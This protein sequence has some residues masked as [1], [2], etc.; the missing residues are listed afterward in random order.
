MQATTI[1]AG[2]LLLGWVFLLASRKDV[3]LVVDGR[4]VAVQ[5]TSGNVAELLASTG[6][7][8]DVRVEPPPATALADGMTVIVSPPPGVPAD[9]LATMVDPHGVG[10]WVVERSDPSSFGKATSGSGEVMASAD[11]V[12]SSSSVSVRAVVSGK[13][14]HVVT[15]ASSVGALLSAMGID[16]DA[17]DRVAPPPTTPLHDRSTVRYDEVAVVERTRTVRVPFPTMTTYTASLLP[18]QSRVLR[19]GA[20]GL[21]RRTERVTLVNGVETTTEVL[22]RTVLREPIAAHVLSG[23]MSMYDGALTE[24]GTGATSQTGLATWYDPP[25]SGL[26]AAHPWLP[27]GTRVTVTDVAT[28]RSVTVVI[29]DRGPFSPGR[30]IDLSPEAFSELAPTGRGVLHVRLDW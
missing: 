17:D 18:G 19:P 9:A 28:G 3:T 23:P 26:T 16:P 5:T 25:W 14:H 2:L 6:L 7:P 22:D 30:I 27:F 10:V 29:D 12:G 15:N 20:E 24:P 13:V 11:A 21:E 1:V 8:S 4:P